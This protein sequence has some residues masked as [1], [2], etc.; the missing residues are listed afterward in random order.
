MKYTSGGRSV[1]VFR[2]GFCVPEAQAPWGNLLEEGWADMHRADY[3]AQ[4][5]TTED[6]SKIENAIGVGPLD[7]EDTIPY[8]IRDIGIVPLPLKYFFVELPKKPGSKDASFAGYALELICRKNP[9]IKSLFVE[10]RR[11]VEGLRELARGFEAMKTGLYR[12]LQRTSYD[13]I[14]FSKKLSFV[15]SEIMG[16]VES[17]IVAKGLLRDSWDRILNEDNKTA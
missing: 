14:D 12:N 15:I 6:R 17:V 13:P 7:T 8:A 16:G 1:T 4:N 10:A 9:S 2:H 5:A 11:S 3:F